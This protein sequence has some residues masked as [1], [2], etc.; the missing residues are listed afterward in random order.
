MSQSKLARD[1]N[2]TPQYVSNYL[3]GRVCP[4]LDVVQ[5]FADALHCDPVELL[6]ESEV[7]TQIA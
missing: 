1:M 6:K 7:F 4:G 3:S 2:A 5:R